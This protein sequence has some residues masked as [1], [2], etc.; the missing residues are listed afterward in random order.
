MDIAPLCT[1]AILQLPKD[2]SSPHFAELIAIAQSQII[3]Q[4]AQADQGDADFTI[5]VPDDTAKTSTQR[6]ADQRSKRARSF[7]EASKYA[8]WGFMLTVHCRHPTPATT[9]RLYTSN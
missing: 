4:I 8:F 6:E 5:H 3:L 9:A 7:I 1:R 2:P